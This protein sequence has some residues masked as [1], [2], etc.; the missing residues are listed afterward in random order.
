MEDVK[1]YGLIYEL[2][3]IVSSL[4]DIAEIEPEYDNPVTEKIEVKTREIIDHIEG[5]KTIETRTI[6]PIQRN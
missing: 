2:K 6:Q 1:L 3:G 4:V 5:K